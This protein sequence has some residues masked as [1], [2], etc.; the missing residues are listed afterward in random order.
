MA[1][2][3]EEN[4]F[5]GDTPTIGASAAGAVPAKGSAS[6]TFTNLQDYLDANIG[7]GQQ[8]A[9]QLADPFAQ[10]AGAFQASAEEAFTDPV[11]SQ[12]NFV[13]EARD[14]GTRLG[15]LGT[16]GG[17]LEALR[18][19]QS[20]QATFGQ[21]ALNQAL[22]QDPAARNRMQS[23]IG[24]LDLTDFLTQ[25][26]TDLQQG[27]KNR[28]MAE[29][30]RVWNIYNNW[31]PGG[32]TGNIGTPVNGGTG[33]RDNLPAPPPKDPN[34]RGPDPTRLP[35]TSPVER[36]PAPP[37]GFE[38][39]ASADDRARAQALQRLTGV[40]SMLGEGAPWELPLYLR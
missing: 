19:L 22:L 28:A 31:R 40:E 21:T 35:P 37:S 13:G 16:E 36:P 33:T 27:L 1:Y 24:G 18:R 8:L 15:L 4:G 3:D 11:A 20:P 38:S 23:T 9:G 2:I 30:D 29:R 14:F 32:Q 34:Q 25:R 5:Q 10:E 26:G 7:G 6:G 12:R 17:R 39:Y